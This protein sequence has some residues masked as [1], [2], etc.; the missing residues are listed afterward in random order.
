MSWQAF[1]WHEIVVQAKTASIADRLQPAIDFTGSVSREVMQFAGVFLR[2]ATLTLA[3]L[4]FW[5]LSSDLGWTGDFFVSTGIFSHWQVWVALAIA[6]H[7]AS[8]YVE[9]LSATSSARATVS[10]QS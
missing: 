8:R 4:A 10:K 3:V 5:R 1:S 6:A 7:A 9:K 2:P